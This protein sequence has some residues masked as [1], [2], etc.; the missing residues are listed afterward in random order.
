MRWLCL[1]VSMLVL[2]V[3]CST[4][5]RPESSTTLDDEED[6]VAGSL[7]GAAMGDAMGRV[8]EFSTLERIFQRYP[9][10]I[11]SFQDFRPED[12]RLDANGCSYAPFSDDTQMALLVFQVMGEARN[13]GWELDHAMARLAQVLVEDLEKNPSGWASPLR[14]PE[15]ASVKNVRELSR[16]LTKHKAQWDAQWWK[17]G[18]PHDGGGGAVMGAHAYGLVFRDDPLRAE[19]WAAEG[20]QMTHGA[21]IS[22]AASAAMATGTRLALKG[23]PPFTVAKEMVKA[24]GRYDRQTARTLEQAMQFARKKVSPLRVLEKF[25][26]WA[27]HEAVAAA[28]FIYLTS[29]DDYAKAIFIAVHTSG[30]SD[31][32]ASMVGAL[33]GARVGLARL[34]PD[35][36]RMVEGQTSLRQLAARDCA[37]EPCP[38]E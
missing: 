36:V 22:I 28:L 23:L 34:P 9:H 18:G 31:T 6:H 14:A 3:S 21:S 27:A 25:E 37:S 35:W 12:F 30:D 26:G 16:R 4:G 7:I 15:L 29:P 11:R 24:A 2:I 19:Y 38:G 32:I 8:V 1:T 20:S 33:V 10:G 5:F 17:A 13:G